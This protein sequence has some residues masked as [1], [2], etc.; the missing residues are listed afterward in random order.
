MSFRKFGPNDI[1]LNT[2]RTFPAVDFVVFDSQ[3][4]YNNVPHQSGAFS[5]NILGIT[6][7]AQGA[8]S[9]Y[10]YNVDRQGTTTRNESTASITTGRNPPIIPFILKHIRHMSFYFSF[11]IQIN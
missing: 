9:L 8:I 6:S 2:M 4:Y 5:D 7:S 11:P 1:V 3:V 10:E